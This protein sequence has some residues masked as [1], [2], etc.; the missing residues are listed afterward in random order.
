[1]PELR[2]IDETIEVEY[3]APTLLEK[4]PRCPARFRWQ[5]QEFQ[6]VKLLAEWQD[7]RRRGRLARNMT[8]PHKSRAERV[9]SW[10]VGRFFFRVQTACGRIFEI[11]YDRAPVDATDRKGRW[12]LYTERLE[13][14]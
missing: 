6:I 5:E 1:M 14:S 4:V 8:P 11:Y 7:F 2:F 3:D 12:V 10:G 9:G 13:S